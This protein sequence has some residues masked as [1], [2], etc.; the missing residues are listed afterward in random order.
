MV[1]QNYNLFRN[2]T[3]LKNVMKPMITVQKLGELP[4]LIEEAAS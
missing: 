3:A 1:F 2:M 4:S